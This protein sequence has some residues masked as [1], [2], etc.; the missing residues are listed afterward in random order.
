MSHISLNKENS[1]QILMNSL[2]K[3]R[4][5]GAFSLKDAHAIKQALNF[6]SPDVKEKPT[7][8]DAP[9]PEIAAI[10]IFLTGVQKA[11]T[12]GGENAYTF[13]EASLLWQIVEFWVNATS[14]KNNEGAEDKAEK[15]GRTAKAT[16]AP[17]RGPQNDSSDDD[18]DEALKPPAKVR[19]STK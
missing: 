10:N 4:L 3:G 12:H 17:L 8:N 19:S 13:D 16:A 5:M 9:D 11:Q 15:D 7:F 6:F 18:E 1:I 2:E 14:G